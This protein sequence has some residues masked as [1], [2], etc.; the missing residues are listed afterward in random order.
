MDDE[1]GHPWIWLDVAMLLSFDLTSYFTKE[2]QIEHIH[3]S[4]IKKIAR[5]IISS[6]DPNQVIEAWTADLALEMDKFVDEVE[7]RFGLAIVNELI[8]WQ[9]IAFP[10]TSEIGDFDTAGSLLGY[11]VDE[12]DERRSSKLPLSNPEHANIRILMRDYISHDYYIQI[13]IDRVGES[14]DSEWDKSIDLRHDCPQSTT[15]VW[16]VSTLLAGQAFW[17][18]MTALMSKEQLAELLSWIRKRASKQYEYWQPPAV[19]LKALT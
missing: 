10:R 12:W 2:L 6:V 5:G 16:Y 18:Q 9:K 3:S 15:S 14:L 17:N 7:E 13:E 4:E 11:L 1:R 19:L 8:E